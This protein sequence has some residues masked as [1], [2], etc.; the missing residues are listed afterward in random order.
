MKKTYKLAGFASLVML[1]FLASCSKKST[2]YTK[3]VKHMP[4]RF[5]PLSRND[6]SL[7]GNLQTEVTIT[8]T[9]S[10][11]GIKPGKSFTDHY[12]K[13][14][15]TKTEGTEI[16]YF[17]PANGE[18]I[19]GSLYENEVFNTVYSPAVTGKKVK[20]KKSGSSDPAMDFAYYALVEK[21]PD[22]DY[23]INVRF[24]REITSKGKKYS[25]KVIVKAD[26]LKLRTD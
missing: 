6:L 22:V 24:D 26:G 9:K 23:F 16:M 13:G 21:Y 4:I 19:T 7:V 25:E 10:K 8:G 14:M 12:K 20:G 15:I 2:T 11:K 18:S 1:I 17:A 3:D 5:K